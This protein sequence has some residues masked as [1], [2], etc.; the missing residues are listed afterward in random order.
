MS[1]AL[2][3][4][5]IVIFQS[6]VAVQDDLGDGPMADPLAG[7]RKLDKIVEQWTPP[8]TDRIVF[9]LS[10]SKRRDTFRCHISSDYKANRKS[11]R[12]VIHLDLFRYVRQ[13]FETLEVPHLEADDVIGIA[14]TS[15]QYVDPVVVSIDKDL[16]QIPGTHFI[17]TTRE[18]LVVTPDEGDRH[19]RYQALVGD[20]VDN[21]PG[22]PGVGPKTANQILDNPRELIVEMK[23]V[24]RGKN[25]GTYK[26][27]TRI[28]PPCDFWTSALSYWRAGSP[29]VP[30]PALIN[31]MVMQFRLAKILQSQDYSRETGGICL[32]HPN[33]TEILYL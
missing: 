29:G 17:P 18:F 22:C 6:A 30:G 16:R 14:A 33:K 3:D 23:R 11:D 7:V 27:I 15:G 12:P 28:G 21:Y 4:G 1:T 13:E 32:W 20:P 9:C 8:G 26:R 10:P 2:I 31:Q 19:W 24:T 25:A 5:D